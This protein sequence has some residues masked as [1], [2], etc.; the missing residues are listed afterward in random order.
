[1]KPLIFT[2]IIFTI[3]LGS[4]TSSYAQTDPKVY[5]KGTVA[6]TIYDG[7]DF[8]NIDPSDATYNNFR[9]YIPYI[10][11]PT[12]STVPTSGVTKT[13]EWI[14]VGGTATSTTTETTGVKWNNTV[15]YSSGTPTKT[16]RIKV[17]FKWTPSGGTPQTKVITSILPAGGNVA[18][19]IEVKYI[20]TPS[21]LSYDGSTVGNGST[22][23]VACG[24]TTS[25]A[26][27]PAVST[28]PTAG[29]TYYWT[30]PS[31]WSGP[32]SSTTPSVT[33]TRHI[34]GGTGGAIKV[35]D[36]RND[37]SN[38]RTKLS[39]NITRPLP[40]TPTITSPDILLCST[41]TITATANN[42][43]SYNWVTTGG[44]SV[45]GT[46]SSATLTG[47]S[48]VDGTVKVAAV[49]SSCGVTTAYST[50]RNI[51]RTAPLP[52]SLLV[53]A[54]GGG[55]P[56]FMCNGFGLSLNAY[57]GEPGTT[58][59]SWAV[60]D[61]VNTYF[62]YSGGTAYFNSYVNSCYGV[63]VQ[64]GNC[65]GTVQKGI[66]ICVGDCSEM[67]ATHTVYPNPASDVVYIAFESTEGLPQTIKLYSEKEAKEVKSMSTADIYQT[68]D[69]KA[70]KVVS[71]EV[72]D[73]PRGIYFLHLSTA[74]GTSNKH[75]IVLR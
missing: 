1:M 8:Y 32:A 14:I 74:K 12:P 9:Y 27:V 3:G 24:A 50:A 51:K 71:V 43:T 33:V 44:V 53:T 2:L 47:T 7:I 29:V 25:T 69:F 41:E 70:N 40:T 23:S 22:L 31:G 38:F 59:S 21:S 39:V 13:Y 30:Y 63:T 4:S 6:S 28:D 42:A 65:F 18:Q 58:F 16:I 75:R 5:V 72:S 60:S 11:Q 48:N 52:S 57:T 54:N 17:T 64:A 73:L 68:Q 67:M 19:P 20:S 66:T 46:G 49:S 37:S 45:S 35:E 34:N 15:N 61:P 36:K 62:N 56:D 26:S 55:S 10:E